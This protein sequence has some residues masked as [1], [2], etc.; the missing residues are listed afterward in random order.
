MAGK[1]SSKGP[2][3]ARTPAAVALIPVSP[4][5]PPRPATRRPVDLPKRVRAAIDAERRLLQKAASVLG[6]LVIALEYE[7]DSGGIDDPDY[8]DVARVACG[9]VTEAVSRLES[10]GSSSRLPTSDAASG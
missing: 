3:P 2:R 8:S 5:A 7:G 1:H 9:M 4:T 6:C 10:V